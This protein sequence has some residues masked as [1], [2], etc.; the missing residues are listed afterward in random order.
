MRKLLI[1][2]A[3]V[4]LLLVSARAEAVQVW[5][6]AADFSTSPSQ[7]NPDSDWY[8]EESASLVRNPATYTQLPDFVSNAESIQG[9][10]Q[11]QDTTGGGWPS[12]GK[13]VT[14]SSQTPA[15]T[16][17]IW[18][19]GA[20]RMHPSTTRLAIVGWRSPV[21]G[22][23]SIDG[24]FGDMDSGCGNGVAWF[25]D[26][27]GT[28]LAAGV[29]SN[30]GADQ[31]FSVGNLPVSVGDFVYFIV[32]P[33]GNYI[34]DSTRLNVSIAPPQA[35]NL[36]ADFHTSPSQANPDSD[37]YYEESTSLTRNPATYTQLPDFVSNVASIQGLEQWQDASRQDGLPA[38]G[39][40][41]TGSSQTPAGTSIIWPAG[42]IRMHPSPTRLAIAGWR[43]PVSGSVSIDGSFG[44]MDSGCGDGVAWFVDLG[45]T[46]LATGVISNGGADQSF[47]EV[48]L[49]VSFGDFVYFIVDPGGNYL[50]DST[51]LNVN[52]AQASGGPDVDFDGIVNGS[53]N[54]PSVANP[55]QEDAVH[56]GG[57]GD[58]CDDPDTDGVFDI[59]DN[60][61]DFV[62][63]GQENADGDQ[64]GDA[65][66]NCPAT[67]TSWFVNPGDTDC[68]GFADTITYSQR[69]SE[70]F[71]G[72]DPN[73]SCADTTT[74]ND[75]RGPAFGEPV[76]PWVTDTNDDGI[77]TLGDI[78]AVA[79]YFLSPNP[80][81][82]Y[83]A[84][85]DWN[86][87]GKVTLSDVLAVA[88]FFLK[89][90]VP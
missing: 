49:P 62:N 80:N 78:L 46:N 31:S 34:C 70:A 61:P 52:I 15:F 33:G 26:L 22:S 4:A 18:P 44:D 66:D 87:D 5:N 2:G 84:R 82:N 90:C 29:I 55:A 30:G 86:A 76:S 58:H 9:L 12:V 43:S 16:S 41:A 19:A 13:N 67:A 6:L 38:V 48:N 57:P 77:T 56:P 36:A 37:W 54:C 68:D 45:G 83:W 47:S 35:W 24:S 85:F 3:A 63:S 72:T 23:V 60:C 27:G 40:N 59:T 74:P 10:E 81:P 69:A 21:S 8:Y 25:V 89:T 53:D 50:C 51:R 1:L 11:W 65:C 79:P 20:I 7:A 64:W 88:P 32:S 75:E 39:K 73:D 42:A 71:V 14:G 28:N 17:V